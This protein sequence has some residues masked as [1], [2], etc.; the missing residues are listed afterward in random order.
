MR[1]QDA[2]SAR[3]RDVA[4]QRSDEACEDGKRTGLSGGVRA[5]E[6]CCGILSRT[7]SSVCRKIGRKEKERA[8]NATEN[9]EE[10]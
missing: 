1:E 4:A 2:Q 10:L 6:R 3:K 7:M 8:E 5:K 9:N